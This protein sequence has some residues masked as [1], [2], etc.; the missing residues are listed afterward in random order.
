MAR[1]GLDAARGCRGAVV[2]TKG[3][4]SDS[5]MGLWQKYRTAPGICGEELTGKDEC[6]RMEESGEITLFVD[7]SCKAPQA[8]NLGRDIYSFP[9]ET[10]IR[11]ISVRMQP[12]I[13]PTIPPIKIFI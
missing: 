11:M 12:I 1:G 4:G 5:V 8:V 7:S 13:A 9:D 3:S 2:T 10:I 6:G